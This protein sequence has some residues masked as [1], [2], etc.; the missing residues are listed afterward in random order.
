MNEAR[1]A[2]IRARLEQALEPLELRI[3]DQSHLHA[4]HAGAQSGMG[5][6]DVFVRSKAFDGQNRIQ[7][8]QQIYAAVGDM[9]QTDI[10]ALSIRALAPDD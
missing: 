2:L 10:H 5:H 9:M 3:K 6:F 7:R 1:V 8:H 4:G